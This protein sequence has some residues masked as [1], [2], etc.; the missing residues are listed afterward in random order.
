MGF[1]LYMKCY[2]GKMRHE[3]EKHTRYL[4]TILHGTLERIAAL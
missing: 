2:S 1:P 3:S 4:T